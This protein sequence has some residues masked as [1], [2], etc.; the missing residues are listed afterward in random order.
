MK[1]KDRYF[2]LKKNRSDSI[3]L[4]K[5]GNFYVTFWQDAS[6]FHYLFHYQVCKDRVGFPVHIL[7]NIIA[8]LEQ[9]HLS[10]F[11]YHDENRISD[12]S[13]PDNQYYEFLSIS[14]KVA[15]DKALVDILIARITSLI[16]A[17]QDNYLK[18]KE[19]I[20]TL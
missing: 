2:D 20:D 15:G 12:H 3:I 10:Y 8:D 19:F 4:I 17:N 11:I 6:L 9:K 18:I 13:F 14:Q 1:L 7:D 5:S 16:D